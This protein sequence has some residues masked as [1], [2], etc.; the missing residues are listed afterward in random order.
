MLSQHVSSERNPV[1]DDASYV[2]EVLALEDAES[3]EQLDEAL[4]AEAKELGL[5]ILLSHETSPSREKKSH[6]HST[7]T[8]SS[9]VPRRSTSCCSGATQSTGLTSHFSDVGAD[10]YTDRTSTP[11]GGNCSRATSLSL[12]D[13]DALV[14]KGVSD[15]R[16]SISFS[17]PA[18]PSQSTFSLPLSTTPDASPR[19][20]F[21][22]IRGLSILKLH[23]ADS[24]PAPAPAPALAANDQCPHCPRDGS[25]ARRAIHTLPCGHRLCTQGLRETIRAASRR[26][27]GAVPSCCGRPIPAKLLEHVSTHAEQSELLSRL[28][29]WEEVAS[30]PRAR[31]QDANSHGLNGTSTSPRAQKR[32]LERLK[33]MPD[34]RLFWASQEEQRDRFLSWVEKQR[35]RLQEQQD[36]LREQVRRGHERE[37]EELGERH[38]DAVAEAEDKQVKA[39]AKMRAVHAQEKRDSATALRHMEAYCA[40]KLGSGEAHRRAVTEQD[41]AELDKAR[42]A[43]DS[44][45]GRHASAINVL[46]GE[47]GQRMRRRVVQQEREAERLQGTQEAHLDALERGF[48]VEVGYLDEKVEGRKQKL[49]WRSLLRTQ[50]FLKRL[51][52]GEE[53]LRWVSLPVVEWP[54]KLS[55]RDPPE[56]KGGAE[57]VREHRA[58]KKDAG[59]STSIAVR[60]PD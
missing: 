12:R 3:E 10:K 29:R 2:H 50:M 60:S 49:Q 34:F 11:D 25:S 52:R 58:M 56:E 17:P 22:R 19:R 14:A 13:Y 36:L 8:G 15:G 27:R 26:D 5:E 37:L 53:S 38:A 23:R 30:I 21:R 32:E 57:R 54:G 41:R 51:E 44:M 28:E 7:T 33:D 16:T 4:R 40:G 39:E 55:S 48:A 42:R 20:H 1:D 6:S 9:D 24:A 59:I 31:R 46:R 18:T 45:D 35:R 43:R 47:Q